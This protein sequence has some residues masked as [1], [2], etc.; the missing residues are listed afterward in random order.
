MI[1]YN[2]DGGRVTAVTGGDAK[3]EGGGEVRYEMPTSLVVNNAENCR[4]A[5][6]EPRTYHDRAGKLPG[7]TKHPLLLCARLHN[8]E[9]GHGFQNLLLDR[10]WEIFRILKEL[11]PVKP[12]Q[13]QLVG[14]N[15]AAH[16]VP[17]VDPIQECFLWIGHVVLAVSRV[18]FLEAPE[19]LPR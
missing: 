18:P 5:P 8:V 16:L 2:E 7:R 19:E 15:S 6:I 13:V 3:Q 4:S 1:I 11:A 12:L 9:V 14:M 17:P 10:E